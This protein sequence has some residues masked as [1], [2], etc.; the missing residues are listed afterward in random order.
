MK[1]TITDLHVGR[2]FLAVHNLQ[3]EGFTPAE[4]TYGVERAIHDFQQLATEAL[5]TGREGVLPSAE[6]LVDLA[7]TNP[8]A[9]K[10]KS[11]YLA[12][13]G[14][15]GGLTPREALVKIDAFLKLPFVV[16]EPNTPGSAQN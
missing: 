9:P 13:V 1:Y 7:K 12:V 14:A 5:V 16:V 11:A 3:K 15:L 4:V 8:R 2:L 6:A 10:E